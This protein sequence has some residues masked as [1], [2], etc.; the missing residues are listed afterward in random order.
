MPVGVAGKRCKIKCQQTESGQAKRDR[1]RGEGSEMLRGVDYAESA[2]ASV[3]AGHFAGDGIVL[4]VG[5][6]KL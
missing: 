1:R 2:L 3:V 6:G 4:F 5:A